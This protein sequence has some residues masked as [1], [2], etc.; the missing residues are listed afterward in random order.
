LACSDP[1]HTNFADVEPAISYTRGVLVPA[2]PPAGSLTLM[3]YNVKFGG[4]R[5]DFF[6]DCHG[7]RV[8]MRRAEVLSHLEGLASKIRQVD[9]DVLFVQE[10]DVNSKRSAFVDQLQWLLDHTSL[11]FARY[12]SQWKADFVPSDGL[13]AVDSGNAILSKHPLATGT[14][15]AL[16]LRKDQSGLERYFYLRRNLLRTEVELPGGTA[17]ALVA[18]HT[19]A[20]SKDGTKLSHIER[21]KEE[22]DRIA[23]TGQLVVGAGDLNTLPPGSEQL[24]GFDD[25]ACTEDYEADD[26]S[27]ET[28]WL[29]PLYDSYVPETALVDYQADNARFFSHTTRSD[30]FWNRKLDY[31]FTNGRFT[32]GSGLTHQD[33]SSGGMATL[34]LS[35]HAPLTVIMEPP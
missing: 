27:G 31:I 4:G 8:L 29:R 7:D 15:I 33:E 30:S 2:E 14:R 20:Y 6:F 12:A 1:F 13:G 21:F 34:P 24:S 25:S 19:E 35:D 18:V 11:N 28:E 17:V 5:V 9:P 10:V 32:P 26:Y 23:E 22:L 3:T 16:A